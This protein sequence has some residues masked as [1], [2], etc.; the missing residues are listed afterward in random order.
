MSIVNVL[1]HGIGRVSNVK[2]H[3]VSA[4]QLI[5]HAC[6][7]RN[8]LQQQ[9]HGARKRWSSRQQAQRLKHGGQV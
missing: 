2:S 1:V 3:F 4:T 9:Y 8:N 6:S 5:F 7:H